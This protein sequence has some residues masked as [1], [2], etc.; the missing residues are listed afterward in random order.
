MTAVSVVVAVYNA[1][2]WLDRFFASLQRQTLRDFEVVMVD[3]AS[4]DQSAALIEKT[5]EADPR[6]RLV[7]LPVNSGAGTARNTG[8]MEARG[9][10]L[11]FADPDDLLPETSLEVRYTA[12]KHHNA[13]V[14]A[15]HDEIGDDG[16]MRNHETRPDRLPELFSPVDEAER[17]GVNPFLCAHWTW[18]FP[19]ELLRRH[20][21]F[22]GEDMRTAE[23]IVL[24]NKLFFHIKRM[25]WIPDTVYLWMKHE[26]S[27]STTRYTAEHYE[28]YFQCCDVFY[29]EAG[30]HRRMELA[31]QFFD[32]YLA[33]Y[34]GHL[35]AQAA[36]GASDELDAQ[37]L[38]AATARI[39]ERYAVFA[40][41]AEVLRRNPAHYAGLCRLMA[42]LQSDNQSAL[43][44]LVESQRVF[45]RLMEEKRFEG[46]RAAGWSRQVSFDKLDREA[47]LVRGR[48]LFCDSGPEERFV[49]GG[50]DAQPAYA[51]NRTVHTGNGYVIFERIL[52]LPLPP[53]GDE[54][55][56]LTVGGQDS[57]LNHT[58]S[59]LR[60]AFA[61]RPLN[62]AGFPPDVRALRRLAA[63]PAVREKFRDAWLFIDR[64]NEADDNA[65]HLYRWV[66]REHPEVNAWFVLNQESHDW[67]RLQAEGF[68]LVPHGTMEHFALFLSASKLVSSQMDVYIYAPLEERYYSDFQ[69]PKFICLQHGVTKEDISS[70]LNPVPIDL[71]VTAS[72]AEYASIVSDGTAYI[73][74]EKEVRLTSFPRFDKLLEPVEQ[75]NTLLVMP[76]WRSD[77]VGEWDGKGQRRE[78]NEAFY[79]SSYVA[80]WK[81]V[82]DDPRLKALLDKYDYNVVFFAHP[83]F[84]EYLDGMPFPAYVDKRSKRHGSLMELMKRSRVMITDFSSVAFDMA[85]AKRS[86]LYYQPEDEAGYARRQNRKTGFF[87]YSTMGFGPVCRDRDALIAALEDALRAGGVPAP[88]Y[89]EREQNTFA[90]HDRNSCQRVFD[91]IRADSKHHFEG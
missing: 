87:H 73:M 9:E 6:F 61:P 43:L 15:C 34:P 26:E 56:A 24:L 5:A 89:A 36:Q 3:D 85:H 70:W 60:A 45:N 63:S 72:P 2:P 19:T 16:S 31:D 77:L 71:F 53:D 13:I 39:A 22:N 8:I 66:R 68:R 67:P 48:Y 49:S 37:K 65:E 59:Q 47:G 21:I 20:K 51:K 33:L 27:L 62:D 83:G 46:V 25:V 90:H 4:T 88:E 10:T 40:R 32:G 18:L 64:D 81:D 23:D 69:R 11:C 80:T 86:V 7:R 52:W 41:C 82:F 76:T 55:I 29:R 57:G 12:Y 91:A 50:R 44:R 84:E 78:R 79:S 54:R 58:A 35:L 30:K 74:T 38:I 14:R 17:V 28:N 75:E 42:V 1:Q